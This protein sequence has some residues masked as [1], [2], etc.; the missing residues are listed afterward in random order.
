MRRAQPFAALLT[1][2][3]ALAAATP[4]GADNPRKPATAPARHVVTNPDWLV[5][6]DGEL[7]ARYYPEAA[8]RIASPGRVVI[9]CTVG[10]D[11]ALHDCSVVSETPEGLHFGEAGLKIAPFLQMKPATV[12]G[13]PV[14]RT[15][16]IPLNFSVAPDSRGF[17]PQPPGAAPYAPPPRPVAQDF[18]PPLTTKPPAAIAAL[19][20]PMGTLALAATGGGRAWFVSLEGVEREGGLAQGQ[21]LVVLDRAPSS[22]PTA[23]LM[24]LHSY[25]VDCRT[26]AVTDLGGQSLNAD[27]APVGWTAPSDG[28][29][30]L[31]PG[32]PLTRVAFALCEPSAR[33]VTVLGGRGALAFLHRT[34]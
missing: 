3:A 2:L 29:L 8:A 26:F 17:T 21:V 31:L 25:R 11:A 6:P 20:E 23:V 24:Q 34:P 30:Y 32:S 10:V 13:V 15:V 19:T 22:D 33:T 5:R 14:A 1:A 4:A 9:S 18:E 27:G 7:L 28:P 12:D 16:R